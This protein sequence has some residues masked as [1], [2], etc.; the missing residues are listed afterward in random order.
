MCRVRFVKRRSYCCIAFV[1]A[2]HCTERR[3]VCVLCF[4]DC[5]AGPCPPESNNLHRQ[6][7]VIIKCAIECQTIS[8]VHV[9]MHTSHTLHAARYTHNTS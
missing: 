1:G 9:D 6:L 2:E 8:H 7:L 4:V 5:V 3:F